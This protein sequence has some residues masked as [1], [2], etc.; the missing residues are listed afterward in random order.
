MEKMR[1]CPIIS[2]ALFTG[3][4][5]EQ[6]LA[7]KSED[8]LHDIQYAI[9]VSSYVNQRHH[10]RIR[11]AQ[12]TIPDRSVAIVVAETRFT[13]NSCAILNT[14]IDTTRKFMILPNPIQRT[15]YHDLGQIMV[16]LSKEQYQKMKETGEEP[17]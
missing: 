6:C 5:K 3:C 8:T 15:I 4:I 14:K 13:A 16:I 10:L 17:K 12:H 2:R 11:K 7:F 9:T 1:M